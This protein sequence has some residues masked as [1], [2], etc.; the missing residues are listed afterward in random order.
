[1]ALNAGSL[2]LEVTVQQITDGVDTSGAPIET[3]TFLCKPF[4]AREAE[5]GYERFGADQ[6]SAA[7]VLKW[8][9]RYRADM[10]P[11]L[12]DVPKKRRL[13]YL[14]RA[15]DITAA[16]TMDRKKGIVLRTLASSK[17]AA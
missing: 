11:D 5:R 10:D 9:M 16:E 13:V 12:V 4:M 7:S 1:M 17:V 6:L 15:Y 8:T 2:N 14:D 3:W